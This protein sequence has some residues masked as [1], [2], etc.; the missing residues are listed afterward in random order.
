MQAMTVANEQFPSASIVSLFT[1]NVD[2]AEAT[3]P[4]GF[5]R[6]RT[7]DGLVSVTRGA[8][9]EPFDTFGNFAA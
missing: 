2:A 9:G 1:V 4:E 5:G 6:L 3:S 7:I 8:W